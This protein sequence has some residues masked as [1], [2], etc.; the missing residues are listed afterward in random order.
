M[1]YSG[2]RVDH[3]PMAFRRWI[4]MSPFSETIAC[5]LKLIELRKGPIVLPCL[6]SSVKV[7]E[8]HNPVT[9]G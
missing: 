5:F 1:V 9:D 8:I 6:A 7:Y 2:S 4:P 3:A